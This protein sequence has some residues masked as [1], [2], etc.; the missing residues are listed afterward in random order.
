M[1]TIITESK[2]HQPGIYAITDT[3]KGECLYVGQ[4]KDLFNRFKSHLKS[5]KSSR[6]KRR[7][8]NEWFNAQYNEDCITFVCLQSCP[9]DETIKNSLEYYWFEVL[10]PKYYGVIPGKQQNPYR[11]SKSTRR[12]IDESNKKLRPKRLI[13]LVCKQCKKEFTVQ[14]K[15]RFHQFCSHD[16]ALNHLRNDGVIIRS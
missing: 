1:R 15:R 8:F 12:K 11:L 10:R 13:Q 14:W 2:I 5:L 6:H 9:N 3:K 7:D 4:S 16:C